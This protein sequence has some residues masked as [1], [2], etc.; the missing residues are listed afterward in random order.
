MQSRSRLGAV[1]DLR[2]VMLLQ[3]RHEISESVSEIDT[4]FWKEDL[5]RLDKDGPQAMDVQA[6]G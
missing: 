2:S 6:D 4:S 3:V 5:R 1:Q